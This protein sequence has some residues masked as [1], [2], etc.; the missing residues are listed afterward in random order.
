MNTKI[1]S[2]CKIKKNHDEY[3]KRKIKKDN[4]IIGLKLFPMCIKCERKNN[5]ER[6]KANPEYFRELSKQNY[7]KDNRKNYLEYRNRNKEKIKLRK[8]EY[9]RKN[10]NKINQHERERRKTDPQYKIKKN[11]RRRVN[12]FVK[13]KNKLDSTLKLLGCS[14][15]DFI[16]Y[17]ESKFQPEMSWENY[18]FK[19]WHIDHIKPC[20]SFDLTDPEEQ[21]KCFHYTNLQPLWASDNLRKSYKFPYIFE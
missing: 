11:L 2:K 7:Y 5:K 18:G 3:Y 19:G 13:N 16:L 12:Q 20:A 4:K 14:L 21:R 8:Q 15:S 17:L 10:K 1:C 9:N 6:Y